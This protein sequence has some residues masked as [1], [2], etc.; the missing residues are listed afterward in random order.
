MQ[1]VAENKGRSQEFGYSDTMCHEEE[2]GS[3]LPEKQNNEK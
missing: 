2:I 1:R 3:N